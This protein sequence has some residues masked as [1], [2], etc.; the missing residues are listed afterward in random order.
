[1][2]EKK[3]IRGQ[4]SV[5]YISSLAGE[6]PP[7]EPQIC[8]PCS[9]L[10]LMMMGVLSVT[11]GSVARR[12][13]HQSVRPTSIGAMSVLISKIVQDFSRSASD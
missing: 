1:M 6:A 3:G 7:R 13:A 8:L 11:Q 5:L 2:L 10:T 9:C 12:F 4:H